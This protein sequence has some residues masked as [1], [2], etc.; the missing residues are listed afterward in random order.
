[1]KKALVL[2]VLLVS[3]SL[4]AKQRPTFAISVGH[5]LQPTFVND[6]ITITNKYNYTYKGVLSAD[7]GTLWKL[8]DNL[9]LYTGFSYIAFKQN[10]FE[11]D[12]VVTVVAGDSTKREIKSKGT[13]LSY[14]LKMGLNHLWAKEKQSLLLGGGVDIS[15]NSF[16]FPD[17]ALTSDVS[18]PTLGVSPFIRVEPRSKL[19]RD[20]GFGLFLEYNATFFYDK[21]NYFQTVSD[22]DSNEPILHIFKLGGT[23]YW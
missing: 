16:T 14:R 6:G 20:I 11:G 1:M 7:V 10:N 22:S 5:P 18:S 3:T 4:F 15:I 23:L 9:R 17:N 8:K 2:L 12:A 21:E 19:N 13:L